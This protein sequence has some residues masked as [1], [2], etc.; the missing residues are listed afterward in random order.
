MH[1]FSLNALGNSPVK[2]SL[3]KFFG[4]M[5]KFLFANLTDNG[6]LRFP[7]SS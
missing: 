2:P 7:V 4:G 1:F 6:L 3:L 5:E